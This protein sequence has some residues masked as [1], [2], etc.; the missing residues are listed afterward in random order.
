MFRSSRRPGPQPLTIALPI[1]PSHPVMR[2]LPAPRRSPLLLMLLAILAGTVICGAGALAQSAQ[3]DVSMAQ[4]AAAKPQQDAA[5]APVGLVVA[6]REAPPF[7]MRRADGTWEGIT[8]DLLRQVGQALDLEFE[9]VAM[10]LDDMLAAVAD[11]E[12]DAAAAALTITAEREIGL[13]FSHPFYASGLGIAA[14]SRPEFSLFAALRRLV[15]PAFLQT[16][17][18]LL[19]I[20]ALVG[21]A[22]WLVERGR[23]EQFPRAP[24]AGIGSGLWWSAVTMTT[25]GYGD[26][27]PLTVPGRIIG[28]VWMFASIIIISGFTAAIATSLT[29][30]R[31]EQS[32]NGIDDLRGRK[33]LTVPASTSASFL[34]DRLIPFQTV[35]GIDKAL[36]G[37]AAGE[38][39]AVVYDMPILR[40]LVKTRYGESVRV[41]PNQFA[42]QEYGIALPEGSP[43]REPLNREI[44]RVTQEPAWRRLLA[45]YL[46]TEE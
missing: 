12:A 23:N 6:T 17:M 3:Q 38:A 11:G 29:V 7:A 30:T 9:L 45:R 44:L 4:P 18:A 5:P 33:V 43:L 13:D 14:P 39:D 35:A 42:H 32:L 8:I 36:A 16:A 31:L 41:L 37:V 28:L 34:V 24:V 46:G 22:V 2:L 20:L 15:S 25:V 1:H 40:Y 26:K 10:E 27:A 19:A 21:G